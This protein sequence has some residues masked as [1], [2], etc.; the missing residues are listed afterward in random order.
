MPEVRI[1]PG[2]DNLCSVHA[3]AFILA[4]EDMILIHRFKKAGPS[5]A[6]NEL[7]V[8]REQWQIT[9]YAV[10]GPILF[11]IKKRAAEGGF[12]SFPS[13]DFI[14]FLGKDLTPRRIR[15]GYLFNHD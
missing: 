13:C 1:T 12:R 7:V 6:R 2:T 14:F 5:G 9:A 10:I 3:K 15:F 8:G 4:T 11:M